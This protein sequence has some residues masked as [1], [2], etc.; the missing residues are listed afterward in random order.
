MEGDTIAYFLRYHIK[1][2]SP[3]QPVCHNQLL[4]YLQFQSNIFFATAPSA[5]KVDLLMIRAS[6]ALLKLQFYFFHLII[7]LKLR[8]SLI[9]LPRKNDAFCTAGIIQKPVKLATYII[10]T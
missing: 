7:S 8:Y 6:C 4:L 9:V 3:V 5:A 2:L 1:I 10:F